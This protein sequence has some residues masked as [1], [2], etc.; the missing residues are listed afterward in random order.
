M[1]KFH[2]Y[3][4]VVITFAVLLIF[5]ILT[6]DILRFNNILNLFQQVAI[7][8]IAAVGMTFA[9]TSGG[10]DLSIGS[11][12]TLGACI[13]AML[14]GQVGVFFAIIFTLIISI[15]WGAFNGLLISKLQLQA[16]VATLAN[17]ILFRG[18]A[19]LITQGRDIDLYE[20]SSI[21]LL[22]VTRVLGIPLPVVFMLLFYVVGF[23]IYK[24]TLFG[25]Y[26]RSIGCN[27]EIAKISGV[28]VTLTT[29]GTYVFTSMTATFSGILLT[30]QLLFANGKLGKGF[31]T[32][33]I[34]A[35]V[36]GGTALSGGRGR[37]WGTLC[38]VILLGIIK[39]GLNLLGAGDAEKRLVTGL[40][41]LFA[42]AFNIFVENRK[43]GE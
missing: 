27:T 8:A 17:M 9:I 33:V 24:K 20:F 25:V 23:F 31:E 43:K 37:L 2:Q 32:D 6:P 11:I 10:F 30:S 40:V 15:L 3:S 36:L 26:V 1:N 41:L 21:K 18:I 28:P 19:L 42:V 39:N 14:L 12:Q 16:F 22:T 35:V 5:S 13:F 38:G 34:S 4:I 7:I 29:I